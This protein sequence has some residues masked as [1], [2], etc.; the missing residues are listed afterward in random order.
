MSTPPGPR[1]PP[2]LREAIRSSAPLSLPHSLTHFLPS[3]SLPFFLHGQEPRP[4][5]PTRIADG[6]DL[7]IQIHGYQ[8]LRRAPLPLSAQRIAEGSPG[9]P[10]SSASSSAPA[11]ALPGSSRVVH[12]IFLRHFHFSE[13]PSSRAISR[14]SYF[15][16]GTP[17]SS[18][19]SSP[20]SLPVAAC[21]E[22]A[23]GE[24]GD[25]VP[26]R[27]RLG[28]LLG[29]RRRGSARIRADQAQLPFFSGG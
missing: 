19:P 29:R 23:D 11:A 7:P 27:S 6:S 26:L 1:T 3:L 22:N 25:G 15:L 18:K 9:S 24:E 14:T 16:L 10:P 4:P 2:L 17:E 5:L 20:C 8:K 12:I 28:R 21:S 13:I